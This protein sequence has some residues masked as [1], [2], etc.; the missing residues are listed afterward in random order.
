[1]MDKYIKLEN[2]GNGANSDVILVKN[3]QDKK[4]YKRII[5]LYALK[6]IFMEKDEKDNVKIKNEVLN[7]TKQ[8]IYTGES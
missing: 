7:L 2:L 5:Q 6:R 3:L 1:M 8:D 4:V